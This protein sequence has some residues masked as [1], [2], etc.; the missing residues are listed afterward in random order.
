MAAVLL[1]LLAVESCGGR[2]A[3]QSGDPG[4]V[5]NGVASRALHPAGAAECAVLRAWMRHTLARPKPA[6]RL[7]V[8]GYFMRGLAASSSALQTACSSLAPD[9]G[10]ADSARACAQTFADSL[11]HTQGANGLWAIGYEGGWVADMAAAVAVFG[12]LEAAGVA[13]EKLPAYESAAAHFVTALEHEGLVL[14][15]GGVGLG[16][17]LGEKA[18]G[19][20]RAW[21][22]DVGWSDDEYMV[23]TALAGIEI[24]AWLFHR[25]QDDKYRARAL[26]ALRV[27][28]SRLKTDGSLPTRGKQEGP[29][30]VAAYVEEGWLAAVAWLGPEAAVLVRNAAATHVPWLLG[31]QGADGGWNNGNPGDAARTPQLVNYLLWV[32]QQTPA[33]AGAETAVGRA[34]HYYF[35]AKA[36][37]ARAFFAD[38]DLQEIHRALAGRTLAALVT[39]RYVQ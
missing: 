8:E 7:F 3:I 35:D 34:R 25:T 14:P 37:R 5:S 23:S 16:W 24:H 19:A 10:L 13:P 17:P 39:G 18:A 26:A 2:R 28:V 30:Q 9:R 20:T 29:L 27:T 22:S 4:A 1:G 33:I 6:T 38:G 21:R 36:L 15:S 31:L 12:A 11:V 32:A